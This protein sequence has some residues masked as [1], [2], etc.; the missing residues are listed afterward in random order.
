MILELPEH[1]HTNAQ[2]PRHV[3]VIPSCNSQRQDVPHR[4]YRA[5]I[6]HV[7][8]AGAHWNFGG[9]EQERAARPRSVLRHV[10]RRGCPDHTLML[11]ANCDVGNPCTSDYPDSVGNCH[12]DFGM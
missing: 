5:R 1:D 2:L 10:A 6:G 7:S 4:I 11:P 12:H 8:H 9:A 3:P